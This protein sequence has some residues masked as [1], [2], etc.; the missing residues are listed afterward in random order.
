MNRSKLVREKVLGCRRAERTFRWL[1][2]VVAL[3]ALAGAVPA[4]ATNPHGDLQVHGAMRIGEELRADAS[5][6]TDADG[7]VAA[8]TY[9]W[10]RAIARWIRGRLFLRM[11]EGADCANLGTGET[12]LLSSS[13]RNKYVGVQA[14]IIDGEGN[15]HYVGRALSPMVRDGGVS[16]SE[17]V[18]RVSE[19]ESG[20]YE[21]ALRSR[22]DDTVSVNITGHAGTDVSV[23]PA[24]LAFT[25]DDWSTAR[26]VTVGVAADN[27]TMSDAAVTLVHQASGGGFDDRG[28]DLVTVL[29]GEEQGP[30]AATFSNAPAWHASEG[31]T[32]RVSF[33]QE[34]MVTKAAMRDEVFAVTGGSVSSAVRA[35]PPSN[36]AWDIQ[37]LPASSADVSVLLPA[38]SDCAATGAVCTSGGLKLTTG[39]SMTVPHEWKVGG[40]SVFA[41]NGD[42]QVNWSLLDGAT[43]YKVQWKSG[44]QTFS[45]AAADGRELTTIGTATQAT[46]AGLT[47]GTRYTFRVIGVAADGTQSM[48]SDTDWTSPWPTESLTGTLEL[49]ATHDGSTSFEGRAVFSESVLV[50]NG[51]AR[52]SFEIV[53]GRLVTVDSSDTAAWDFEI[54]P[55]GT[56]AV[57]IL[58]SANRSCTQ[59]GA[60]CTAD[61]RRLSTDLA[62]SVAGPPQGQQA[63][64]PLAASFVSVPPEHDGE[65]EFWLELSF[66]A[67]V[68]QGSKQRIQALLWASGGSVTRMRRKDRRLDHWRVRVEPSSHEAVTVTLSPSPPCGAAGAVCTEDGRT[69]TAALA[70]RIQGPPGLAVA[71]AEVE[72][73]ANATLAFAV[74][75]SR[76]PSGTVTV[77]YAT[78]DG[79]AT[80][81][82]DYTAASGT[83]TFA[84]GEAAKTISVPVLDDAHDEGSETLTLTLSNSSGAYI[85]DGAATG[86]I[87]NTDHMPKAWIARFGRTVAD[88]VLDAVDARLG[89]ARTAGMSVSLGGQQIGGAAL[90]GEANADGKSASLSGGTE[91]EDTGDTARLKV[92]SDWLR[93]ETSEE[94]RS[95]GWSRTMT[96]REVL[97]GSSFSL[98]AQTGGGG[99]AGLWGRMAQTSFAGR[100]GT[101]SLDGDVT[102]GLL[103]ADYGWE[104]WTTGLVVSHSIGEG[105]YR[106]ESSG[107]IEATVTALTPWAR[108]AVTERLSVWGAAGYGAGELKLNAGDDPALKTDLG[109]TLAAAGVRGTLMGGDGPKLDAVTDARW[110]RTTTASGCRRQ[111]SR[112][113]SWQSAAAEVT[114]LRL[115]LEG[116]WPLALGDGALGKGAAVTPRLAL[117]VRHD[118]GD[119]ETGFGADIGGGL[120]L[121]APEQ[122]LTVSLEGRG[123]LTHEAE[124]LR[125]RGIAGCAGLEPAAVGPGSEADAEPDH[126][127]GGVGRQGRAAVSHHAGGSC[128]QRQRRRSRRSAVSNCV[129]ATASRCSAAALRARRRWASAFRRAHPAR[130]G[131]TAWAGG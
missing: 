114:R 30:L 80:A 14:T 12:Y 123:V 101:L 16:A 60:I 41:G 47:A 74:T 5:G 42:V 103:G 3:V 38:T 91:A 48:P 46:I 72:E 70:T 55:S 78:S 125:D 66:D 37:V 51:T 63:L 17:S 43:S 121:A 112:G 67:A 71:D 9:H 61:W 116:S 98:T 87:T 97:M 59:T 117:G 79:T 126:R 31:F 10:R 82:S 94:E 106:G 110:V 58:V 95:N 25:V 85:E 83:L 99:F 118:G 45:E 120:T 1:A 89:A 34:V 7:G 53:N 26:T 33:S 52:D 57:S 96:G 81:G 109:M 19:G 84:A 100:E 102:T 129:R 76:A 27:D 130:R 131:T 36:A 92:L 32:F 86:T 40:V 77:D 21:I 44:N 90:K 23:D 73:A 64:A 69:F 2:P 124:G 119:A 28:G 68:E 29:P 15:R 49:P 6:I 24:S 93:Q 4:S 20:T 115:G 8:V 50:S 108:Y 35:A 75:L 122:G 105:G 127:R 107:E 39:A 111:L 128:G 56:G 22:P 18:L 104:R 113:A 65:T 13:D 88:Q 11:C 62:A 54:E